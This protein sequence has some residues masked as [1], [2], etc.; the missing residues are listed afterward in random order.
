MQECRSYSSSTSQPT[1]HLLISISPSSFAVHFTMESKDQSQSAAPEPNQSNHNN[2]QPIETKEELNNNAP[3]HLNNRHNHLVQQRCIVVREHEFRRGLDRAL[4]H[5]AICCDT[6]CQRCGSEPCCIDPDCSFLV[7]HASQHE[8][9]SPQGQMLRPPPPG[10]GIGTRD[11]TGF[12]EQGNEMVERHVHVVELIIWGKMV[13]PGRTSMK[14]R[15]PP[16]GCRPRSPQTP[17]SSDNGSTRTFPCILTLL[18]F[19]SFTKQTKI[20]LA[21][22]NDSVHQI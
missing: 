8:E 14:R 22:I 1:D 10:L 21:M 3:Q 2:T 9:E 13:K 20:L 15:R 4:L 18:S 19:T 11:T 17:A 7:A 5:H 6:H 12:V 16:H